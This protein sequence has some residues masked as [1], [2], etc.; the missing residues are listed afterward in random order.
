MTRLLL[1]FLGNSINFRIIF[2]GKSGHGGELEYTG[3]RLLDLVVR[4]SE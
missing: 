4:E 3:R 1:E 2:E